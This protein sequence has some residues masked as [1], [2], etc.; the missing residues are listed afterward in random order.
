MPSTDTKPELTA[1][2]S[3]A[4]TVSQPAAYAN[5][6]KIINFMEFGV[7]QYMQ[8]LYLFFNRIVINSN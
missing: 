2:A 8:R 6:L 3:M 5:G 7:Y 1:K 4:Q